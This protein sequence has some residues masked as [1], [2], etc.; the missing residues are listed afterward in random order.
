MPSSLRLHLTAEQRTQL[1]ATRDHHRLPYMRERAAAL[2]KVA[3][4][5][6]GRAVARHGLL[7]PH[8][9]DTVYRWIKRFKAEGLP[10]LRVRPGRGRKPAIFP[11]VPS[12]RAGG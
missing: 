2:L 6:S 4:G 5:Q 1:E 12:R 10:G 8:W 9:P 11:A 7:R 3:D